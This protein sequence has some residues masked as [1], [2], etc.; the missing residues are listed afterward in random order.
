MKILARPA[1]SNKK[2][3][4]YNHALY[5]AMQEKGHTVIE[6]KPWR[7]IWSNYDIL[8]IHWPES[9]FKHNL[10]G[11]LL[12]T[13][14]LLLVMLIAKLRGKKIAWTVHNLKAHG[15][16]YP[17]WENRMWKR[18]IPRIDGYHCLSETSRQA[19]LKVYPEL[20]N[21]K[22]CVVYHGH[23]K[24][25]YPLGPGKMNARAKLHIANNAKVFLFVGQILGYKNVPSLIRVFHE[26]QDPDAV[27]CIA[28]RVR[29]EELK[30]EIMNLAENDPRVRLEL[31]F[32]PDQELGLWLDAADLVTL[33]YR[34]ILNSGSALLALSFQRP[35]LL[36]AMGSNLELQA[37]LGNVWVQCFENELDLAQLEK[38]MIAVQQIENKELDLEQLSWGYL[39]NQTLDFYQELMGLDA[40]SESK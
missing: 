15:S 30:N 1:F 6:Y 2:Y 7:V 16:K 37:L 24:G 4:P 35:I 11:A 10:L 21:K 17:Y 3:N 32:I 26:L 19:S 18:F 20:F 9:S 28:G 23:Y 38:S 33:P 25:I 34:E 14:I 8:H 29:D 31:S 40:N 27:L 39:A 22:S 5:S 12:V 13:E 36:P